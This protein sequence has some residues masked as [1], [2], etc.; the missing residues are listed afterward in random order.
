MHKFVMWIGVVI[1]F[2]ANLVFF[3]VQVCTHYTP[4]RQTSD[5]EESCSSLFESDS[6]YYLIIYSC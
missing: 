3:I 4:S 5:L 6:C 1:E 2:V